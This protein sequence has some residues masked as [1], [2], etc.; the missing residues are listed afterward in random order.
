MAA[1]LQ[2]AANDGLQVDHQHIF[3][4]QACGADPDRRLLSHL[5][6]IVHQ[7][8]VQ[9]VIVY[10]PDRLSRNPLDLMVISVEDFLMAHTNGF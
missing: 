7:G 9:A 3:R 6:Q 10:S 4:E 5:R 2:C 8:D 1:C